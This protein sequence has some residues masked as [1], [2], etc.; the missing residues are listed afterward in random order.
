MRVCR[1]PLSCA[2][3]LIATMPLT[4]EAQTA[5]PQ[6]DNPFFEEW[7][8]PF[9]V[10]PFDRIKPEHFLPAF[11]EAVAR[12]RREVEA[13]A[14]S[15]DEPTFAN[16]IEAMDRVGLLLSKVA[17]VFSNLS[18][19]N[20]TE[21]LQA[22]N[23][24]V[25]P[26]LSAARDDIRLDPKLFARVDALWARRATL[27]LT[28]VQA[29]LLEETHK[30]FVRGGAT[31][32]PAGKQRLREING[33][34]AMLGVKFGD[35]LLHDTNAFRLVLDKETDLDG[36]PP[37][38]VAAAAEAATKAGLGGKWVFT[39]Q[40][41]SIWPFMQ[42][43]TNRDLR[44]ELLSAYTS[45]ND[46]GDAYDN[47]AVLLETVALR[48]ERARLLG[49][50]THADFVL[51][52]NMA[53]VPANVYGLLK[54]L[55]PPARAMAVR[56]AAV[57]QEAA[58]AAGAT[59]AIEPWDWRYYT[60]KV[61]KAR[62][63]LDE[64]ALRPYFELDKVREGVFHVANALYGLTFVP[65]PDLP[66]YHPEVKAFEVR[67]RDGSHLGIFYADYHPR[68]GKR[69]G[70][71][72][73]RFREQRVA[74]GKSIRPVV[75]NVCNFS[76][77]AGDAPAL[78]SAEEVETLFHEFGHALH[79]LLSQVPY[80]GLSGVS[81][82][83]VELPSQIM[84]N[85]AFEPDVLAVYAK[86]Y[87]TGEAIP[88]ALVEKLRKTETFDQGFATVEY[89]AASLLDM[90]WHTVTADRAVGDA[91][92][93]ERK[94]LARIQMPPQIVVRYRSPYFSHVF[95]P[96][97][98]YAAGYY[99][100]IWAEVLDADAFQAFRQKGLFDPATARAFRT[101]L[102]KGNSEDP[103]V[104]YRTFRGAD[105]NVAPLLKKRGLTT[106]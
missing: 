101:L 47:K 15:P 67:D 6:G 34:L 35:N 21:Q 80:R 18:S 32:D 59:F 29:R 62:Y 9:G 66:S 24:E 91:G 85:W 12:Q 64:Q 92:A 27:G 57:L 5:P 13:I 73:S 100:Y 65:R 63:D 99:S 43:A 23:R 50:A 102:E 93:F 58:K 33:T 40:A 98:G 79:S 25:T 3:L 95:G 38:V 89:L 77:P 69:V 49:F 94:A 56:E 51:D 16:T 39:L 36:L 26:L 20:T 88:A 90:D 83:F 2:F 82:D 105:P 84:E 70:A 74:D 45:R 14:N 78:L 106:E 22:I 31:L 53:K 52:E 87:K 1:A 86:H 72:S 17:G 46:H 103:A 104:L 44:K 10:P 68:P 96:G 54:Q 11:K 8:T 41:P 55:W 7:T 28:A 75:V 37:A 48:A 76:R 71:W 61:R 81:R 42:Y 4:T 30:G 60:E 19:A 97:G